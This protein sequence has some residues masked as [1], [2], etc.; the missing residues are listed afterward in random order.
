VTTYAV[1]QI[2]SDQSI[3]IEAHQPKQDQIRASC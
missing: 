2:R 1:T 3:E